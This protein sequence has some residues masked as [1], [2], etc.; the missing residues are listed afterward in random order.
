MTQKVSTK[1]GASKEDPYSLSPF[2]EALQQAL[3]WL[4]DPE[5]LGTESPLAAPYFLSHLLQVAPLTSSVRQRGAT[6]RTAIRQAAATLWGGPLPRTYEEMKSALK[7]ERK[8][9]G[10]PRYAYLVL[11]LRYFQQ[12]LQPRTL[13][14]IYESDEYLLDSKAG[15]YRAHK[16]ALQLLAQ[17][18]LTQLH[19]SLRHEQPN[20][21]HHV[22]GYEQPF[23]QAQQQLAAGGT[24]ALTGAGGVGKTTLGAALVHTFAPRPAF[25]FTLR[26]TLNDRLGSLLFALG[27]FFQILGANQLWRFLVASGGHI[28]D[29]QVALGLVRQDLHEL[30]EQQPILCFDELDRLQ[31]LDLEQQNSQYGQL[32]EF[33]ESLRG[34][35]PLL[36]M[37]QRPLFEVDRTI[38]LA[39]FTPADLAALCGFRGARLTADEIAQL[40]QYTK[41][42]PRLVL[43]CLA[44][45]QIGEP[46][47]ITLATLPHSLSI[48]PLL[49]RLW[50]RLTSG[51][52][53]YLQQLAVF[54]SFAPSPIGEQALAERFV[55]LG[56]VEQDGRG[57]I[58]LIPGLRDS[59]YAELPTELRQQ[60]HLVASEI[61]AQ[62]AEYTAAAYHAWQGGQTALAIQLWYP[63]RQTEIARGQADA[64]LFIFSN[65]SGQQLATPERKALDLTRAELRLM[66][67]ELAQGLMEVEQ[68]SWSA[69]STADAY[70]AVLRGDLQD[71]LGYPDAALA[72]YTNGSKIILDLLSQLVTFSVR[73]SRSHIAQRTMPEA[74]RIARLAECQTQFLFGQIENF[75]GRFADALLSY[76]KALLMAQHLHDDQQLGIIHRNLGAIY[77]RFQQFEEAITHVQT[78]MKIYERLGDR[79]ALERTRSDLACICI[80]NKQFQ[81]AIEPARKAWEFFKIIQEPYTAA[82]AAANLAEAY[83]ELNDWPQA[84]YY[85]QAVLAQEEPHAAPYGLFTLGR[86]AHA[87]QAREMA[88][89]Y[90]GTVIQQARTNEDLL[91]V[92]HAERE[93]GLLHHEMSQATEAQNRLQTALRLFEQM[94][95]S[96]EVH[97]THAMLQK[98]TPG[99]PDQELALSGSF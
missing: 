63:H 9:R 72:S 80:D 59:I 61:R 84:E 3:K 89:A 38:N 22:I 27:H 12:F 62:L 73:A 71:A 21:P 45:H 91:M 26:P 75:E 5:R 11:E 16:H 90:F 43:L 51:E 54:R 25:W 56:L 18:L 1:A 48:S 87:R 8:Q 52:R 77:G 50:S 68:I 99:H 13:R 88:Q 4:D 41:G 55:T 70:A 2:E 36:F 15:D 10:T 42:N 46:L 60:L 29:H 24:V 30:G 86:V 20:R 19:P 47:A 97:K 94:G 57:G 37:S 6:L 81:T 14:E 35:A 7:E 83:F 33:I 44:L 96:S 85:A 82:V 64:A 79:L 98:L 31:L 93:L 76:Q 28:Q 74:R 40:F 39:G 78:A 65:L 66:R 67:G 53:R 69:R 17:A 92:A 49:R 95:I 58:A 34:A 23:R 32:L